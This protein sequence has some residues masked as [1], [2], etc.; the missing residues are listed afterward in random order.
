[1]WMW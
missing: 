1:M